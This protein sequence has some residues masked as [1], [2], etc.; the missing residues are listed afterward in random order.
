MVVVKE[1]VRGFWLDEC[2]PPLT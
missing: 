2:A 1:Q